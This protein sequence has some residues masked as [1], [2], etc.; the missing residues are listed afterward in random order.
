LRHNV[1]SVLDVDTASVNYNAATLQ[2]SLFV[3]KQHS[4]AVIYEWNG[5][6]NTAV[7]LVCWASIFTQAVYTCT[8]CLGYYGSYCCID[9]M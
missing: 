2:P 5:T 6:E 8:I 3:D 1:E 9:S 4:I 7:V